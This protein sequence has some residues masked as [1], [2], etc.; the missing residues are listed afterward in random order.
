MSRTL[1]TEAELRQWIADQLRQH[2]ACEG[3]GELQLTF[4]RLKVQSPDDRN[5]SE[6]NL[7]DAA[8]WSGDC[9]RY[10]HKV[11]ANAKAKFNL[12]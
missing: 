9:K 7:R 10:L 8:D 2:D 11:L 12:Q 3:I 4:N 6:G 1:K 5:W